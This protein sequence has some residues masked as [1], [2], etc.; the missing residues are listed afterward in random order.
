MVEIAFA[1]DAPEGEMV[2][3]L[4]EQ[5]QIPC[6]LKPIGI[7]GP[8]LGVGL[9]PGSA[10]RVMVHPDQAG[11]ARQLLAELLVKDREQAAEFDDAVNSEGGRGRKPRNYN[12]IGA[13]AR[14]WTLSLGVMGLAFAVFLLLR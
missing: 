12:I 2:R 8:M 14:A 7:N 4:L 9:L 5:R 11:E 10:Q 3:G 13:Y 1:S 6:L